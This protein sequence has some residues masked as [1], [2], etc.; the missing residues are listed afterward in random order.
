MRGSEGWGMRP[1]EG[2]TPAIEADALV[3]LAACDDREVSCRA[4]SVLHEI[5]FLITLERA[6]GQGAGRD[7]LMRSRGRSEANHG[8]DGGSS[9]RPH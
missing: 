9:E 4:L 6:F 2:W 7:Y 1:M 5:A 8:P 3:G